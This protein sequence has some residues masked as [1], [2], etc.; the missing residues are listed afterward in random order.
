MWGCFGR[1]QQLTMICL[2][3]YQRN[4]FAS[5]R[6]FDVWNSGDFSED[7]EML[8]LQEV[9]W[10]VGCLLFAIGCCLLLMGDVGHC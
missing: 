8:S 5:C 9:V 10:I 3:L 1:P 4:D 7:I 2:M 6:Y